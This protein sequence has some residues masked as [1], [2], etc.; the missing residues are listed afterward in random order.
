MAGMNMED[1][2]PGVIVSVAS[3]NGYSVSGYLINVI[4]PALLSSPARTR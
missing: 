4:L 3:P 2:L 1:S